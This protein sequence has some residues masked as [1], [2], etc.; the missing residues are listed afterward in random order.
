MAIKEDNDTVRKQHYFLGTK[1]F[2]QRCNLELIRT[3]LGNSKARSRKNW[4]K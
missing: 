4:K 1:N 3:K 2:E